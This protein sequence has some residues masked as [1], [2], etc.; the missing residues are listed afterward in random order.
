MAD[1]RVYRTMWSSPIGKVAAVI[2]VLVALELRSY[3]EAIAKALQYQHPQVR[4]HP[5][6]PE[7]FDLEMMHLEPH[8]VICSQTTPAVRDGALCWVKI[9]I[10]GEELRAVVSVGGRGKIVS[11]I[12]LG[13]LG[14]VLEEAEA[15]VQE[16]GG[17]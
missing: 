9:L 16:A 1:L 14:S 7:V 15:L 17:H 10:V 12:T 8:V 3:R 4:V 2:R 13:E 11:N 5:A 6:D